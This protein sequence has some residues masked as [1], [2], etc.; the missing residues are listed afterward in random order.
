MLPN[1]TGPNPPVIGILDWN[2]TWIQVAWEPSRIGNPGSVFYTQ[3]RPKSWY[4]WTNTADEYIKK[5]V[6]LI[7]LSPGTTYQVRTVA[8]NGNGNEAPSKWQEVTTSGI[9]NF[10]EENYMK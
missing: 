1:I 5:T 4:N 3:Y 10:T 6:D 9:G 8:K 7:H 2:D